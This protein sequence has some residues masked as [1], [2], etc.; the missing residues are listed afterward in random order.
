MYARKIE[1]LVKNH[2]PDEPSGKCRKTID[3]LKWVLTD[4]DYK[5]V[6]GS[7]AGRALPQGEGIAYH[8]YIQL[9]SESIIIDPT[10]SQFTKC[11][12]HPNSAHGVNAFVP[13]NYIPDAGVITRQESIHSCYKNKPPR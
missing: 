2:I 9:S 11:N 4:Y 1:E 3:E 13:S 6:E 5:A 10:V 8:W 7:F 12:Y